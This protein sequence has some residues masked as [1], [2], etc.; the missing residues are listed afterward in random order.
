MAGN[1][2]KVRARDG[3]PGG[4]TTSATFVSPDVLTLGLEPVDTP[5]VIGH[6]GL[7][8]LLGDLAVATDD[9]SS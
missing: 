8:D 5:L 1:S 2:V 3:T 9:L 6:R 7:A 4:N